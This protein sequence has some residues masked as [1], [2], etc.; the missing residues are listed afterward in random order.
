M[1]IVKK[2]LFVV[3]TIVVVGT[4]LFWAH[5]QGYLKNTPLANVSLPK[6]IQGFNN[7]KNS[8]NSIG[9]AIN[10][11]KIQ[12]IAKDA[13]SQTQVLGEKIGEV[14]NHAQKVL[15]E[16]IQSAENDSSSEKP[17]HE[18]TMEYAQYIYCKQVV[19]EYEK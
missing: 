2:L 16:S 5:S 8:T 7:L 1:K 14:S 11:E 3:L 9:S 6:N 18:K 4:G 12:E 10:Q 19:S 15:G 17:L 13:S